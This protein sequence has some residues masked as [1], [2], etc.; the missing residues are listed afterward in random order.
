MKHYLKYVRPYFLYFLLAP[1]CM[2]IEVYADV[3]I[4]AITGD[5]IDYFLIN[6]NQSVILQ[7]G[8]EICLNVLFAMIG[9][10]GCAYFATH[11]AVY[12]ASD[13]RED[14][15]KKIQTFSFANIDNFST[16]SLVTRLTNDVVQIQGLVQMSLRMAFRAPSMLIGT[17]IMIFK[18][19]RYLANIFIYLIPILIVIIFIVVKL[20]YKRFSILQI[21]IDNM[22]AIVRETLS[23]IR[24]IKSFVREPKETSKFENTN[25]DLM[26]S[27]ISAFS[28]S[29][30]Q[31]PLVTLFT[32]IAIILILFFGGIGT[33]KGE[34]MVGDIST[35]VIY[36]GQILMSLLMLARVFISASRALACGKRINEIF[37]T[38]TDINEN[39]TGITKINS[40]N[41]EFKNVNFKYYKNIEEKVLSNI[42]FSIF[43]GETVGIIGSTGCGKSSLVALIPRLYDVDDGEILI[44]GIN[45]KDFSLKTLR[46]NVSMVLQNNLLFSGS[47]KSNLRWGDKTAS[48]EELENV[49]SY[50]MAHNFITSFSDGYDTILGQ[51]GVNL[52]GGQKQRLC[53]ARA[54]LKKPRILILDDST[55]AVDT[56]TEQ[57]IRKYL[58]EN[59][60]NTTKLIIAQRITSVITADKIIVLNDGKIEA[61]G[62][63]KTLLETSKTYQE[64]YNSQREKESI[65]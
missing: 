32:N 58:L 50:A 26:N 5:M 25:E 20:S 1:L 55:S 14:L 9:G 35:F 15:F 31:M 30:L 22:N 48:Q 65:M 28:I 29:M 64:I 21:K 38:T 8:L 45:I 60:P 40:G 42:N 41:I 52:S 2:I 34:V 3:T 57:H 59:L 43:S 39:F 10:I 11:A 4:P 53:I 46:D 7:F 23:N 54:L 12:F 16:P 19:N 37:N 17:T 51:G 24:V 61:I 49:S 63:H 44:D 27:G 47:I 6:T 62:T 36:T 18:V 13:L 33:T 56:K